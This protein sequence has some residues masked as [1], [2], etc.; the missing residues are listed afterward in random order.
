MSY[1]QQ[2]VANAY[3]LESRSLYFLFSYI[4][5]KQRKIINSFYSNIENLFANIPQKYVLGPLHLL[6]ISMTCFLKM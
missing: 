1:F 5:K 2:I 4:E 3:G 6:F